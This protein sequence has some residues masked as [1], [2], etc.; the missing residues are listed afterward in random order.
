MVGKFKTLKLPRN[1][2]PDFA[3]DL[4]SQALKDQYLF[5]PKAPR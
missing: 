5:Y 2:L 4:I 3:S 1:D